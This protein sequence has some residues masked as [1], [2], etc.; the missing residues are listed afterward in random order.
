MNFELYLSFPFWAFSA[1]EQKDNQPLNFKYLILYMFF[2]GMLI[3]LIEKC[4]PNFA[5]MLIFSII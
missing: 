5:E 3:S 4:F 2:Y 1:L